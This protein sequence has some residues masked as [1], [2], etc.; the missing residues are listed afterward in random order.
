MI[1]CSFVFLSFLE[2]DVVDGVD[3]FDFLFFSK[4]EMSFMFDDVFE[5]FLFF[6]SYF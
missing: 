6:V 3:M 1:K 4:E 5:F 2:E